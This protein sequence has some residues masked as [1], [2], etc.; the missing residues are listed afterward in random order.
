ME[1]HYAKLSLRTSTKKLLVQNVIG[2]DPTPFV[3]VLIDMVK[4]RNVVS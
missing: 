2:K 1:F 4:D 3:R